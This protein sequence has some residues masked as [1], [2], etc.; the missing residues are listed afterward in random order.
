MRDGYSAG[1]VGYDYY[2]S[3]YKQQLNQ[4]ASFSKNILA[5]LFQ[6]NPK[7]LLHSP[8][9]TAL[10]QKSLPSPQNLIGNLQVFQ[11]ED[12]LASLFLKMKMLT[13]QI[14]H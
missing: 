7:S 10:P 12:T 14:G 5:V 4:S 2:N 6:L 3:L 11:E 9:W 8:L 1:S 13:V